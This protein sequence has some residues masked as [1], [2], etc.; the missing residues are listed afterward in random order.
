MMA[1]ERWYILTGSAGVH[2]VTYTIAGWSRT[3]EAAARRRTHDGYV[4]LA[5]DRPTAA[6]RARD[7]WGIQVYVPAGGS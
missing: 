1:T 5:P 7:K 2:G 4:I 6:R 3:E